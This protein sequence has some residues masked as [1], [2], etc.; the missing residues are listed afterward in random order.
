MVILTEL[1]IKKKPS[2]HMVR[3]WVDK[4]T[5]EL[6]QLQIERDDATRLYNQTIK[7]TNRREWELLDQI[8]E[9]RAASATTNNVHSNRR[10]S[11]RVGERVRITNTLRNE[12]GI[13]GR[14]T[15]ASHRMV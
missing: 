13:V 8:V 4:L 12:Y 5:Q 3:K 6:A 2:N 15:H 9:E 1:K 14:V 10:N 7:S 11:I